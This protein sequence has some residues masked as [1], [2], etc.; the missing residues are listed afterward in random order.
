MRVKMQTVA[1][2]TDNN[3][4]LSDIR[5]WSGKMPGNGM[6]CHQGIRRMMEQEPVL[7][8]EILI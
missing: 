4:I 1:I 7:I 5:F 6:T 8:Q 2:L 3:L